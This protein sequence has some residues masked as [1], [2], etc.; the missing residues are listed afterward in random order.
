M[1]TSRLDIMYAVCLVARYQA[2]PKQT[3]EKAIKRI[4]KYLKGTLDYGL[5]SKRDD[6]FFLSVGCVTNSS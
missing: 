2:S 5:W 1:T 6:D 3:N 4:F